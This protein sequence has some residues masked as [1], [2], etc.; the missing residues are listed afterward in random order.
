MIVVDSRK[1]TMVSGLSQMLPVS[2]RSAKKSGIAKKTL[3]HV[4]SATAVRPAGAPLPRAQRFQYPE[5]ESTEESKAVEAQSQLYHVTTASSLSSVKLPKLPK[6]TSVQFGWFDIA[7][8][9]FSIVLYLSDIGLDCFVAYKHSLTLNEYPLYF[10]FTVA[11]IILST[12]VTSIFSLWWYYFEY[13]VKLKLSKEQKRTDD[14]SQKEVSRGLMLLRVVGSI[15][16]CGP[17]MRNIDTIRYGVLSKNQAINKERRD[18]YFSE[19]KYER[20][21]GAML[22]LF[23]AFLEAG[24]QILLQIFIT[25]HKGIDGEKEKNYF[26]GKIYFLLNLVII[27]SS[28]CSRVFLLKYL[29]FIITVVTAVFLFYY[30]S[31]NN[32]DLYS[33]VH[34]IAG[35]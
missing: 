6:S 4:D 23:E 15:C 24:P 5:K 27:Y 29:Y 25:L 31:C 11:F 33:G 19:M 35:V 34:A 16:M 10:G 12:L 26:L 3:D 2:R 14:N 28:I 20:V 18:Y 7:I 22:R 13:K 1:T 9:A 32:N 8:A 30:Y 21:D 17:I